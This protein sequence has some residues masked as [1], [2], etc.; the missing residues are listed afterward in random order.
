MCLK[1]DINKKVKKKE[2]LQHRV[3]R[4]EC[5]IRQLKV[6]EGRTYVMLFLKQ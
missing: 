2:N 1:K 3:Y 5:H 6:E 4:H